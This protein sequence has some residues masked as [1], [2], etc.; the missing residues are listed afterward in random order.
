M[1]RALQPIESSTS[2]SVGRVA[3]LPPDPEC[4]LVVRHY[5]G[6][7]CE[8]SRGQV[9]LEAIVKDWRAGS[10]QAWGLLELCGTQRHI[11]ARGVG[12]TEIKEGPTGTRRLRVFLAG[13]RGV[14]ERPWPDLF[15][16]ELETFARHVGCRYLVIDGSPGFGRYLPKSYREV[17]R[18]WERELT[19]A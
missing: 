11:H 4:E 8:A 18:V 14:F 2:S 19:Q 3:L 7:A 9:G 16:A 17:H 10:V 5:I 15:L 6:P 13:G 12:M 1:T